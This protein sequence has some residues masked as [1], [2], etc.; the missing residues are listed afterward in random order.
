M[1]DDISLRDQLEPLIAAD[2]LDE[3]RSILAAERPETIATFLES[4]DSDELDRFAD[5]IPVI[6]LP[7]VLQSLNTDDAATILESLHN[8]VAAD[9]ISEMDPAD[10]ADV[11]AGLDAPDARAVLHGMEAAD[12]RVVEELMAY[13]PETAAGLMTPAF[14]GINPDLR[15]DQAIAGLRRVAE[16]QDEILDVYV[17]RPDGV[18]TGVLPLDR[19]VLSPGD[20]P[21][22]DMMDPEPLSVRP[23]TD[24]EE[25]ARLMSDYDLASIPVVDVR[26]VMIG[27][28]THDDIIDVL[29]QETTRDIEQ[30]GG[31]QPLDMPYRRAD[32]MTLWKRRIWWLLAL[33][34]AE[35]YT[36]T[37]LRH[38][39]GEISQVVAL[40][41]FIPLLIGTGGNVGTQV[42]TTLV[43]AMG[44]KEL[45]LRD[46]R[47][48]FLKEARVGLLLGA[49][50]GVVAFGRAQLLHVGVDIGLVIAVTIAAISIWSASVA[51]MLPLL[52]SKLNVDPA[53]VSAPLISTL[54]DG[55]GLIIYFTIAKYLL[56]L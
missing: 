17:T 40:S 23:E 16:E 22:A 9:V 42:T 33:F 7:D 21:V 48:V 47:W 26:G 41:F 46:V 52:L 53:V 51:S 2:R 43:R 30:M 36:G 18:L 34:A 39:E 24:Q 15:A 29:E 25:V 28:I 50:M 11:L 6:D 14:I 45:S 31:S 49:T 20:R 37:V 1:V 5:L 10:A 56:R 12:A 44:L 13:H 4:L 35:A 27:V 38:Y 32:V 55:T 19:L 54:V 3:V 8:D